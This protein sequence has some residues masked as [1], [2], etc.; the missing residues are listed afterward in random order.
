[1]AGVDVDEAADLKWM[2]R[3]LDLARDAQQL[4]EVPVGAVVVIDGRAVG[5]GWN[6]PIAARDPTAHA[7]IIALR[8]AST[9]LD[10]Y[11]I[12]GTTLYVT[13]EPCAMCFAAMVYARVSRL[14]Y[15]AADLKSGALSSVLALP[16]RPV[17]NHQIEVTG[18][19]LAEACGE[20]LREFFR[21]RR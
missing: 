13:L 9:T 21:L 17:F 5:S 12:P 18:G 19:L 3:A 4:N 1:M 11:R 8:S 7:E 2:Q 20:L 14:V 6:Q 10:N 16:T 15:G